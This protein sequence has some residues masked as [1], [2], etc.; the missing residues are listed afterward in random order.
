[1]HRGV[2]SPCRNLINKVHYQ[3]VSIIVRLSMSE[4]GIGALKQLPVAEQ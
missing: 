1:M 3:V 2:R 4:V